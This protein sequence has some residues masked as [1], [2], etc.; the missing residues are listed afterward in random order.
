MLFV[1]R[2]K[3]LLIIAA[4]SLLLTGCPEDIPDNHP[5]HYFDKVNNRCFPAELVDKKNLIYLVAQD[6][7]SMDVV[8]GGQC[9]PPGE[10]ES[11]LEYARRENKSKLECLQEL[12]H[13][14]M[15]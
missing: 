4:S 15:R 8:Y 13:L 1:K 5:C 11:I 7:V 9:F 14:K 10:A 6:P 3:T 12:S 2:I